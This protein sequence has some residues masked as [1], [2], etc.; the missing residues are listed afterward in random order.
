[1][2]RRL[3]N[4]IRGFF[5]LFVSR[6]E[7]RSPEALLEVE[8]ENLRTN[9]RF[10]GLGQPAVD[11]GR[12]QVI[13]HVHHPRAAGPWPVSAGACQN[14]QAAGPWPVYA[15]VSEGDREG[16]GLRKAWARKR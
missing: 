9:E 12:G 7:R 2:F 1:M 8:K 5:G 13:E 6:A 15:A 16:N 4:L 10:Q 14:R 3:W 11:L